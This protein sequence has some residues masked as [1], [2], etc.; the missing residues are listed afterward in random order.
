[1]SEEYEDAMKW[2]RLMK[3]CAYTQEERDLIKYI[4]EVLWRDND[5]RNS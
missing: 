1:M 5:M 2:L 4:A 3:N